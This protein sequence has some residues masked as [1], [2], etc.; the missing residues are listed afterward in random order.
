[1]NFFP[2]FSYKIGLIDADD[3]E[4]C[5]HSYSQHTHKN[6]IDTRTK[7]NIKRIQ[8]K[9]NKKNRNKKKSRQ[10]VIDPENFILQTFRLFIFCFSKKR[11]KKI[12]LHLQWEKRNLL[13]TDKH[14]SC[15]YC[16]QLAHSTGY[17][18]SKCK[19]K[20]QNEKNA[21]EKK[22]CFIFFG[23]ISARAVF[24]SFQYC[25][26]VCCLKHIF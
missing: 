2:F 9:Q 16:Y 23:R 10:L 8:S 11:K 15:H 24:I 13:H 17:I 1:M 7:K 4:F 22:K 6:I 21:S 5:T 20:I 18:F 12:P 26:L 3:H 19:N 25:W 14:C